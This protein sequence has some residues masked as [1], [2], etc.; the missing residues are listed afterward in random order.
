MKIQDGTG[1]GFE[2]KIDSANRMLTESVVETEQLEAAVK[3]DSYQVGSGPV[4]LTSANESAVLFFKNNEDKD[5]IITAANITSSKQTGSTAGVF[6]VKIYLEGSALSAGA[7]QV[8]V[9]SN[10]GSNKA[11]SA[12]VTAGQEAATVTDGVAN[13]S[14]YIQEAEFFNTDLAW[15]LPKGTSVSMS[16]TPGASNTSVTITTTLEAHVAREVL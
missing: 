12:T 7:S 2:V 3:G 14:F 1:K 6:L 5:L 16:I 10:F 4:T 13:G 9:N 8:P 15:V 11:L